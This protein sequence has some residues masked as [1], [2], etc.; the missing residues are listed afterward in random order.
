MPIL[1]KLRRD[2]FDLLAHGLEA[3]LDRPLIWLLPFYLAGIRAGWRSG[4]G[5]AAS[6]LGAAL[7]LAAL[8][9]AL[10]VPP[11]ASIR[12]YS[13]L[14]LGPAALFLGWGLCARSLAP[15]DQP[16][17][18][19]NFTCEAG[20]CDPVIL[21][22]L[23]AEGSGGRPGRNYSLII[24]ARE[25]IVPGEDG[26]LSRKAVFGLAR[27]S[28][29]QRPLVEVGDYLRL[30]LILRKQSGYKNPGSPD[31]EKYW[32]AQDIWVGGFVKSPAMISSWPEAGRAGAWSRWRSRALRF[33]EERVPAPASGILAA[34]LAGRRNAVAPEVEE[35]FRAL[36]L[37][38]LLSV[39]GLHLGVWYGLCFWLLRLILKRI[40]PLA[41]RIKADPAAAFLALWPALFYAGLVGA[42]S[43]VIRSAVMISAAVLAAL[44]L[45][46]GDPWNILAAAAWVLLLLEPYRLLTASFQL[47]F[48]ATAAMLAVFSRRPGEERRPPSIPRSL[49]TRPLNRAWLAELAGRLKQS[50]PAPEHGPAPDGRRS[51][52]RG[53]LLAALAGTLGTAPVVIWHFGRLPLAGIAANV[54]FTALLSFSVLLPGLCSLAVLPLSPE[55]AGW[56]L[57]WAGTILSA[58]LPVLGLAADLAGPGWLLPA[59]G[60]WLLLAW[61]LAGWLILR[62]PR[63]WKIRLAAGGLILFLGFLPGLVSGPGERGV[64]RFT[65][66]DVGQGSSIHLN[67]PDG[68]QML[69]DGGGTYQGDPG[70]TVITPYLLRRG[71]SRLDVSALTHPDQDHLKGLVLVNKNFRPR[72]IWDGPWPENI[73]PLYENFRLGSP[74]SRRP[75]LA[76]LYAGRDF[77]PARVTLLWP[78][79]DDHWPARPPGSKWVNDHGL[80]FRVAWGGTSFLITGDIG[81]DT[82]KKM[83]ELYGDRLRSTVLMGP[84]H[85]SAFSLSEEFLKAV[86]P[87][88]VVFAAG[89]N[90]AFNM[91]HPETVQRAR[92]AGAEIWRTDLQGA[93]IF[94]AREKDGRRPVR[95]KD[96]S[97]NSLAV[98]N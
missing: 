98:I 22:G 90:N 9:F 66:L 1:T 52:F 25:I 83:A 48:V 45:R 87:R 89:R 4:G 10:Q 88:W 42:A 31:P 26:P 78:P 34:Q 95:V 69:V 23:V 8:F 59:P 65:V 54:V 28:V 50:G 18:L 75:P 82:E 3:L 33:I 15:P 68:R 81:L 57:G 36:G 80:V 32:G 20:H 40:G 12:K 58:L 30:P 63:P 70:E 56:L 35:D 6:A 53:A 24:D 49:W 67:L 44:A 41:G 43:P 39:S 7:A 16:D 2:R 96:F 86:R 71:L 97:N 5:P 91:P 14:L 46:R 47:S 76:E 93:A 60:P 37:S 64:L 73:S 92:A 79:P 19:V 74:G 17:H 94:E 62:S 38:H 72:E 21:G 27:V 61:Y 77:G 51:F 29:G 55:L 13:F 85:G 84:H 11:L